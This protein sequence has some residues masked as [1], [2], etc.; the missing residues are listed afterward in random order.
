MLRKA[1]RSFQHRPAFAARFEEVFDI[2]KRGVKSVSRASEHD[3]A[4]CRVE[5]LIPIVIER[6]RIA[7]AAP[8][9][10]EAPALCLPAQSIFA[11][12]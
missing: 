8:L 1:K 3:S 4:R 12:L 6:A 5:Q 2:I 7:A 9:Q 10:D 11:H